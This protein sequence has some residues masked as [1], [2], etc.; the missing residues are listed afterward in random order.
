MAVYLVSYDLRQPGQNYQALHA[1]L[2]SVD[3]VRV[4]ESLWLLD[5]P[6]TAVQVRDAVASYVDRNDGVLVAEIMPGS[7]W[8]Y[9]NLRGNTGAWLKRKRP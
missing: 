2:R 8:A 9:V 7:D 6:Q 3:S 1:E 5:V 4:L